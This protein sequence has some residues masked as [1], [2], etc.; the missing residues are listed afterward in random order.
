M[1]GKGTAPVVRRELP[2]RMTETLVLNIQSSQM[3]ATLRYL[4]AALLVTVLAGGIAYLADR[5][6]GGS[7]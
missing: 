1:I 2:G 6:K 5:Q 3:K 4:G 7:K